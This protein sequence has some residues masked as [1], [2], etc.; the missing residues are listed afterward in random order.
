MKTRMLK[1]RAKRVN[2]A[3]DEWK[4]SVR[5]ADEVRDEMVVSGHMAL[6]GRGW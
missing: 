6:D 5:D 2:E 1:R 4:R 3:N